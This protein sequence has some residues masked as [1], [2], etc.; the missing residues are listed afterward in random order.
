MFQ[1]LGKFVARTWPILLVAWIGLLV[2]TKLAAPPWDEVAQDKEFAFLPPNTPS[3]LSEE[4]FAKAFPDERAG[5]N[6][7]L[8][9]HRESPGP[10]NLDG[11]K[12]FIEDMLEPGL[13]QVAKEE[14]GLASEIAPSEGPE[15]PDQTAAA[16]SPSRSIIERI[17]T[18]NAPGTGALLVSAD[19]KALLV[20]IDLTTE[21]L[22]KRNWPTIGKINGLVNDLQ[23]QGKV[24]AGLDI[25]MTGSA[26]IGRDHTLAE[27]QSA[28]DTEVLTVVLVVALL[29]LIYQAPLLAVIGVAE[30]SGLCLT[31]PGNPDLH[32]DSRLRRR[33]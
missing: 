30:Q 17:R 33:G 21:F 29:I 20:V 19:G 16:P 31:F 18:P 32:H 2:G 11:D 25:S 23:R 4:L 15:T 24:P 27:L 3:R 5:S 7:V 28:R 14:G 26:V 6:V 1:V 22:S 13:R 9:L 10:K 8:V 12:K